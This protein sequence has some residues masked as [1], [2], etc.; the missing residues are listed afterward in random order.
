[1][2]AIKEKWFWYS[3]IAVLLAVPSILIFRHIDRRSPRIPIIQGPTKNACTEIGGY[4]EEYLSRTALEEDGVIDE[5][6]LAGLTDFLINQDYGYPSRYVSVEKAVDYPELPGYVNTSESQSLRDFGVCLS[7]FRSALDEDKTV[8]AYTQFYLSNQLSQKSKGWFRFRIVF[9]LSGNKVS[10][11][12]VTEEEFSRI[13]AHENLG[14]REPDFHFH[15]RE[16]LV[17]KGNKRDGTLVN[18]EGGHPY[19]EQLSRSPW[20]DPLRWYSEP[21]LLVTW[22]PCEAIHFAVLASFCGQQTQSERSEDY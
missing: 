8:L 11:V 2:D 5:N 4:I 20:Q 12:K 14:G 22:S 7:I 19:L 3:T 10:V 6:D 16:G 15:Y 17:M 18:G 13:A 21:P 9:Y 1:M